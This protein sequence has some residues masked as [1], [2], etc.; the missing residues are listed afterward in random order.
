[1]TSGH[2]RVGEE[3]VLGQGQ[4]LRQVYAGG[5]YDTGVTGP[6][7]EAGPRLAAGLALGMELH[8]GIGRGLSRG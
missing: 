1:M 8:S 7:L 6:R 4:G 3:A 2:L 5:V